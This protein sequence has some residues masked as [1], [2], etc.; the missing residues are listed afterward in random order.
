M[1][2]LPEQRCVFQDCRGDLRTHP[3]SRR[4]NS[5]RK[6]CNWM[7]NLCNLQSSHVAFEHRFHLAHQV[8]ASISSFLKSANFHLDYQEPASRNQTKARAQ[9]CL[10]LWRPTKPSAGDTRGFESFRSAYQRFP[11]REPQVRNSWR[12]MFADG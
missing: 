11:P 4:N 12:Q 9:F 6:L 8:V 7:E 1:G 10:P 2:L 5:L 3:C